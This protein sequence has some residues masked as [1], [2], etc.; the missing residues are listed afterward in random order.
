MISGQTLHSS[1]AMDTRLFLQFPALIYVS[2]IRQITKANDK[3]KYLSVREVMEQM[4]TL[5]KISYSGKRK[6]LLTETF[7][8]QRHILE[9]FEVTLPT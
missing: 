7:P 8:L 5:S 1:E 2:K 6:G 3:L 4:E 9:A